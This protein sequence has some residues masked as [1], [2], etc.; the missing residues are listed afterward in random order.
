MRKNITLLLL[1][2]CSYANAQNTETIA[3]IEGA[4][5]LLVIGDYLYVAE[6]SSVASGNKILKID[7]TTTSAT[8]VEVVKGVKAP[9]GL[10]YKG[11]YL[12][13]AESSANKISKVDLTATTPTLIDVVTGLDSPR[14]MVFKGNDLYFAEYGSGKILKVDVT[15]VTPTSIEVV[16]GLDGPSG[17]AFKGNDLYIT[18]LIGATTVVKIDITTSAPSPLTVSPKLRSPFK[19]AFKGDEL[20]VTEYFGSRVLKFNINSSTPSVTDVV[21]G[22]TFPKGITFKGDDLFV[23]EIV[24]LNTDKVLKTSLSTT[25]STTDVDFRKEEFKFYPNPT[26]DFITVSGINTSEKYEIYNAIGSTV[27]KGFVSDKEKIDIQNL[28][29]GFYFLKVASNK[30]KKI[31]KK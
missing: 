10:A 11:G 2:I 25:L 3:E 27:K 29:E 8:P 30:T 5:E 23:T 6:A 15:S 26:I 18:Q 14:G 24:L 12:Y 21:T 1:L 4:S 13:I 20:F 19:L 22:V 7:V 16:S 31:I 17:I 9:R 28:S